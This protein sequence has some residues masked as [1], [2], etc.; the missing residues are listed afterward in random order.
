M[1]LSFS[2]DVILG[3]TTS[4]TQNK[5]QSENATLPVQDI[6]NKGGFTCSTPKKEECMSPRSYTIE[7]KPPTCE[8]S[9][10]CNKMNLHSKVN[11]EKK[12]LS[13]KTKS[14][15]QSPPNAHV[16]P[17]KD[18]DHCQVE[19]DFVSKMHSLKAIQKNLFASRYLP[20]PSE[21]LKHHR[22]HHHPH[23]YPYQLPYLHDANLLH[24]PA[25]TH[26][27]L[28]SPYHCAPKILEGQ[29]PKTSENQ[30]SQRMYT[31]PSTPGQK[32][33]SSESDSE[34]RRQIKIT[35]TSDSDHS[36]SPMCSPN[37]RDLSSQENHS[38]T[39]NKSK[40]ENCLTKVEGKCQGKSKRVGRR[41]FTGFQILELEKTFALKPY[42]SRMERAY[43]SQK[44]N[45]TECQ[46]KTW[47]QNRRTKEKRRG[48]GSEEDEV[49]KKCGFSIARYSNK[50]VHIPGYGIQLAPTYGPPDQH[51]RTAI[52]DYFKRRTS[53]DM[54]AAS[55]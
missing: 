38:D 18:A 7:W 11:Q 3:N 25:I 32:I 50:P 21:I 35:A 20:Y 2:I 47:F 8:K 13:D 46:I 33:S 48:N 55:R 15:L 31:H 52:F 54:M 14:L 19:D 16:V 29:Y 28:P 6:S 53:T 40:S 17:S 30:M 39:E 12:I 24:S 45:L 10:E 1:Q 22:V 43:I 41:L 23:H 4:T 51:L 37:D 26:G 44:V 36:T 42:L 9:P 34:D 27:I 49:V 5:Q